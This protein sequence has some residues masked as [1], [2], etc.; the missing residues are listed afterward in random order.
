M[1]QTTA[2]LQLEM[3]HPA[4]M[5]LLNAIN[6]GKVTKDKPHAVVFGSR[7]VNVFETAREAQDFID[8]SYLSLIYM[9]ATHIL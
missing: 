7:I 8:S 4:T 2:E 3:L 9:D 5:A 1:E 6:T